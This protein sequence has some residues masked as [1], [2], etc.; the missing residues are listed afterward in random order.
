[1]KRGTLIMAALAL[2]A[3]G[4]LAGCTIIRYVDRPPENNGDG[5]PPRVV[6]MLVMVELDRTTVQ[7][8]P[9]YQGILTGLTAG[10]AAQNVQVR[11]VALAPMYRRTGGAVPLIYGLGDPESEFTDY[12]SAIA[13]FAADDGQRYLRDE[14]DTDGENLAALGL[15]LDTSTVYHPTTANTSATPYFTTPEDGLIVV[16]LTARPRSCAYDD[17]SCQLDGQAPGVYFTRG[18]EAAD[19]LELAGDAGLPRDRVFFVNIATAEGVGEDDF[20]KRCE[21]KPGFDLAFLDYME[22]SANP[23]YGPLSEAIVKQ[24]GWATFADMC[25]ALSS[26]QSV[27]L[28]TTIGKQVGEALREP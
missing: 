10:L 4:Q 12:G 19:W 23:Y 3:L 11:K 17:A 14:V 8:A 5:P 1:M 7:L 25:E 28:F 24:G 22:P 21:S 15:E 13:F 9:G 20:V 18:G 16:Q 2:L 6:D 27:P 26:V